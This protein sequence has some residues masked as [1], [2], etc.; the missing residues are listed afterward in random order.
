MI[1]KITGTSNLMLEYSAKML[2]SAF[3]NDPLFKFALPDEQHRKKRLPSFFALNL[4]Y[5]AMFGEVYSLSRKAVAVWLPPEKSTISLRRALQAGKWL[6]PLKIGLRAIL[7]LARLNTFSSSLHG[8]L[9]PDPHWYL[10][11]LGV[12]PANQGSGLGSLLLQPV[13]ARADVAHL[14][15]YLE[16]NN[17]SAIGFYKKHGFDIAAEHQITDFG[18]YLWVMRRESR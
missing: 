3:H 12:T 14:P 17:P 5:G 6:A 15:C 16:T 11:L 7:R 4:R 13:L 8:R 2:A 1:E 9:A 18:L 10:F